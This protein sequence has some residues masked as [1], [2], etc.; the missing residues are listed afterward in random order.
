MGCAYRR[1]SI[2]AGLTLTWKRRRA[3]RCTC[4]GSRGPKIACIP[5]PDTVR[6]LKRL[7]AEIDG[8]YVFRSER[9]SLLSVD[10][11]QLI[12]KRAGEL[13]GLPFRVHPHKLRHACGFFLAEEGVD[14]RLI[15]SY[16]RHASISN[17][18]IYTETSTRRLASIRVR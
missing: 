9:G 13:T 7:H 16:L 8:H 18:V 4:E 14:T 2:C 3:A 1:L 17:T 10:A 15:Q 5:E 6:T 11:V 12:C